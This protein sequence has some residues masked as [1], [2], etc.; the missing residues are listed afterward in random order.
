MGLYFAPYGSGS[1]GE[2]S[3]VLAISPVW[4]LVPADAKGVRV[5]S[6]DGRTVEATLSEPFALRVGQRSPRA[7]AR[8]FLA[9]VDLP[10]DLRL[11]GFT[12]L[13]AEATLANGEVRPRSTEVAVGFP[14]VRTSK[15]LPGSK[16]L[17]MGTRIEAQRWETISYEGARGSLCSSAAPAGEPLIKLTRLQCS[18]PL[19]IIDALERFGVATY[20]SETEPP[21]G[22]KRPGS[23][24]VR[25]FARAEARNVTLIDQRGRT[26]GAGL[27]RVWT[28]V[29]RTPGD[30]S[31][32]RGRSRQRFDRLPQQAPVRSFVAAIRTPPGPT[33]GQGVRLRVRLADGTV[34]TQ[35]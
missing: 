29:A 21:G 28:T 17:A 31:D 34:L 35:P 9:V 8:A 7:D 2:S 25:G 23:Y 4:G 10:G 15:P 12:R 20:P 5:T 14:L 16:R 11:R 1:H 27:S 26:W 18:S 33:A 22:G 19:A 13:T 24:V 32:L 6:E 3:G 30:T